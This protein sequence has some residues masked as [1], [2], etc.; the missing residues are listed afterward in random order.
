MAN[1]R[2]TEAIVRGLLKNSGYESPSIRIEEQSSDNPKIDNLLKQASKTGGGR[3]GYPDFIIS[4]EHDPDSLVVIECKAD[5]TKH[6]SNDR[7]QYVTHAVDGALL[8]AAYLKD[9]F[10]VMAIAVSGETEREKQVSHFLWLKGKLTYK[11][12]SDKS[13]IPPSALF[14]V[15][16]EQQR[17]IQEDELIKSAIKYNKELHNHSIPEVE[18]CTYISSILVALQDQAFLQSYKAHH[19]YHVQDTQYNPNESLIKSLLQSCENILK[20]NGISEKKRRTILAEYRKI[21]Q[22]N[23]LSKIKIK[24]KKTNSLQTNT[25]LRDLIDDISCNVLPYVTH[26]WFDVLGKFY[27]QFIR[28]AGSDQKTGL[29]LTPPHITDFFCDIA[30]VNENDTVFDPCCGTGGFLVSA[31]NR[32]L[33]RS[34][35]NPEKHQDIKSTQIIGIEERPDMFS[36]ACSNMMMRGDGKS[37][38]YFG[39]CFDDGLK[40]NVRKETPTKIFLNPPYDVGPDGQL[41]FI[42]NAMD[43]F[44]TGSGICVSICQ[45]SS[46]LSGNTT[47]QV[48]RRLLE[49]HTLQAVMS[50]PTDLFHPVGVV[51]AIIVFIANRPHP[52]NKET[53]F[54]YFKDDGFVKVKNKGR[55]DFNDKWKEKRPLWI[56]AFLNAKSIPGLSVMQKVS[57]EDEW[58]AEAY[59]ET[60]YSTLTEDDFKDA[61]KKYVAYRFMSEV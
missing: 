51:T 60:D 55:I 61:V 31:M 11:D 14:S 19:L 28:Y 47:L 23:K 54:G 49:K 18:R 22:N 43:C 46:V 48:K 45:M 13:I 27:T 7:K 36:H 20:K 44:G 41:E 59:M 30:D 57:A 52:Q 1:E 24:N 21:E 25:I 5:I 38:I 42:E 26:G 2:K 16:E 17:P 35:N 10:N 12:V 3:A 15:I 29:V 53:F 56:D 33:F 50:M 39:D 4:F 34:G 9:S 40:D 32:M 37:H 8:Y 58:C 6:E